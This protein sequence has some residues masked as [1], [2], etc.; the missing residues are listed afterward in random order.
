MYI[1]YWGGFLRC[2]IPLHDSQYALR[3][4]T[5]FSVKLRPKSKNYLPHTFY[6]ISW[7][8]TEIQLWDFNHVLPILTNTRANTVQ[9]LSFLALVLFELLKKWGV[10]RNFT[11]AD[12]ICFILEEPYR[13]FIVNTYSADDSMVLST[14]KLYQEILFLNEKKKDSKSTIAKH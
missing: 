8:L 4:S 3:I 13:S 2:V 12:A 14:Y 9:K 7:N 6:N 1:L 5:L 11:P 10:L